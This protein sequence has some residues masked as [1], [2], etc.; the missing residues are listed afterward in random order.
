MRAL[1]VQPGAAGKGSSV[2]VSVEELPDPTPGDGELLVRGLGIGICGTDREIIGGHYGWA[3][4]GSSRLVLGHESF[5][6]VLGAPDGSGFAEGDLV[7]GVVRR[8]DPVPCGACARGEFD[9]CRNGKY[10]E[11]GIKELDGY[12]SELWTVETEYAVR[13]D[14]RL[15]SVGNLMEPTSVVAKAWDQVDRIGARSWFEPRRVLITG[16]GPIGLLAALLGQQRG[17]DTHVVDLVKDGPKPEVVKSLGAEYHS[18][19]IGDVVGKLQPDV[20][21]E[22]TGIGEVVF[23]AIAATAPYGIVCLTGV[24][25]G[26]HKLTIDAGATNR[27]MVLEND[28]VIGSVNANHRHYAAAA[29]AL[30][31]AD[32][33]WL[34]RLV[35]RRVPL[36][37]FTE[38]L[39]AEADDIKVVLTL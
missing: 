3:P 6:R 37:R 21:I 9:M 26:G 23:D 31:A 10:T 12:G 8:P 32:L 33:D 29:S 14:P 2:P 1:T 35:S 36:E 34:N 15:E 39:T 30:A 22:A 16:A 7:A 4:P 18:D 38:A 25:A 13:V 17:L 24:S 20:V 19:P 11:R 28:V 5:G 27:S